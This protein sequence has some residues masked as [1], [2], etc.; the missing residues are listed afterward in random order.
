MNR[1][2]GWNFPTGMTL[3]SPMH[4]LSPTRILVVEDEAMIAMLIEDMLCNLG[5]VPVGPACSAAKALELIQS[6]RF[7]GAILDVN[8]G[9]ERTTPVA[10]VLHSKGIPFFFATGY[11]P[12]G[13]AAQFSKHIVLTKPF[14]QSDL[15]RALKGLG[16]P[17]YSA[18]GSASLAGAFQGRC[19]EASPIS[20]PWM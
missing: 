16:L 18:A 14:Q 17:S 8:L 4:P 20:R 2:A 9:G 1:Q 10:E 19:E 6:E 11:G 5:C 13:V 3:G 7:D 15:E 12:A